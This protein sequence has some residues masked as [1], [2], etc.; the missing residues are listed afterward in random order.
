M[1]S[2][3]LLFAALFL[4]LMLAGMLAAGNEFRSLEYTAPYIVT[5]G[6]GVTT[7]D[8]SLSQELFSD[9]TANAIITSND[10]DD[11]PI[12]F[13]YVHATKVLTVSG[14]AASTTRNLSIVYRIDALTD[15]PGASLVFRFML[16]LLV[17]GIIGLIA[18]SV[19]QVTR[20]GRE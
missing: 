3:S 8:I 1:K 11:A 16:M 17:V 19:Y 2:A 18:G 4:I 5:T 6:G 13:A 10:T 12:P 14:L 7:A 20:S 9:A 15:W